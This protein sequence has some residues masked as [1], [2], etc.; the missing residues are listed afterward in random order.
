MA[1]IVHSGY[2]GNWFLRLH[3]DGT[4]EI[5]I[6]KKP[7]YWDVITVDLTPGDGGTF[8]LT[9]F[10]RTSQFN[11]L[12]EQPPRTASGPGRAL[13]GAPQ[14]LAWSM[15]YERATRAQPS[16]MRQTPFGIRVLMRRR[17]QFRPNRTGAGKHPP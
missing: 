12:S 1:R 14:T 10:N 8:G 2:F 13:P 5:G 6:P 9:T 17:K 11:W 16:P 3:D 4:L 15:S 7:G